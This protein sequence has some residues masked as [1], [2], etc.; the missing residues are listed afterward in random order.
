MEKE[1]A[2]ASDKSGELVATAEATEEYGGVCT[3]GR[4]YKG[5]KLQWASKQ[6][7]LGFI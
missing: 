5:G 7:S 2:A 1:Q 6:I 4:M 3:G